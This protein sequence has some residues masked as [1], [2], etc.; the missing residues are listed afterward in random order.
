MLHKITFVIYKRREIW[1]E[2]ER[3]R[4][5]PKIIVYF[6]MLEIFCFLKTENKE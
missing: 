2:G 6:N 5:D 4:K 3:E 1:I